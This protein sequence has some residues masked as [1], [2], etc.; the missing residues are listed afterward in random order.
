MDFY[1]L[2]QIGFDLICNST[3][4]NFNELGERICGLQNSNPIFELKLYGSSWVELS[5]LVNE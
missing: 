1:G 3:R 5:I 4:S 2:S